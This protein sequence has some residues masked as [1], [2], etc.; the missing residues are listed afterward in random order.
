MG[1]G[2]D[3]LAMKNS[4]ETFDVARSLKPC[5][6]CVLAMIGL[7]APALLPAAMALAQG[8][9]PVAP[10]G[11]S[12]VQ[13]APAAPAASEPQ[14]AAPAAPAAP[15][16]RGLFPAQPPAPDRPGFIF[17]FGQWWDGARGQFQDLTRQSDNAATGAE[18]ATQDPVRGAAAA[19]QGAANAT[20]DAVRDAAEATR[21]AATALFSLPGTRIVEVHQRCDIAPNGAP[22]CATAAAKA[23]RAKGF[24]DGHPFNVQSDENCPPSVWMSGREP[25]AGECPEETVVLMAACR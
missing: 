9:P 17:A 12:P 4:T 1:C 6:L 19:T 16:S 8:A 25:A 15:Q 7:V 20:Q 3:E 18:S 11:A 23:C 2:R 10:A 13:A 22:D 24:G 21:K 14:A 5:R